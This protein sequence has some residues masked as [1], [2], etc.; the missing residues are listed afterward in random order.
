MR[1]SHISRIVSEHYGLTTTE[2]VNETRKSNVA[3]PRMVAMYFA[4]KLADTS[5][6]AIAMFFGRENHTTVINAINRIGTIWPNDSLVALESKIMGTFT[7]DEKETITPKQ[8]VAMLISS[9]KRRK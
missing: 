6:M 5:Q 1:M 4:S 3:Y 7:Q 9:M 2:L 8:E